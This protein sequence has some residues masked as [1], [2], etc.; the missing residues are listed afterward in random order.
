LGIAAFN[1]NYAGKIDEVRLRASVLSA[2][3]ITTEYNNQSDESSFWP[4]WSDAG[5]PVANNGF[6][7]WLA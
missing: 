1:T 4:T 3:W 5:A 7:L 6:A 2:N